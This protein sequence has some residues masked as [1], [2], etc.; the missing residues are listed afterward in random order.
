MTDA[1]APCIRPAHPD[2]ADAIAAVQVASWKSSYRGVVA[3]S[4]LDAMTVGERPRYWRG[5]I[6][7][8]E[9]LAWVAQDESGAA[10]GFVIGGANRRTEPYAAP[11]SAELYSIYLL[12]NHQRGG[13]GTRLVRTLVAGLLERGER[14]M[15]VMTLEGIPAGAFYQRLGARLLGGEPVEIGGERYGAVAYGWDD[16]AA[17]GRRLEG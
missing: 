4:F 10:V 9:G 14:S 5:L 16:L 17:L 3:D 2:D 7:R 8:G 1:S 12:G 13:T 15:V 11:F 6:E